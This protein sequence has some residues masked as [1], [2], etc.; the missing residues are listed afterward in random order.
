MDSRNHPC[1]TLLG[2]LLLAGCDIGPTA[3]SDTQ[4]IH[5]CTPGGIWRAPDG[6]VTIIDESLRAHVVQPGG[7]QFVGDVV[8]VSIKGAGRDC[9]LDHDK[10]ELHAV[11]PVGSTLPDGSASARGRADASW[12]KRAGNLQLDSNLV[13]ANNGTYVLSFNGAYDSLHANDSSRANVAGSY[14]PAADP[15]AEV[16]TIDAT[17]RAF[18]QNSRTGCVL[19][20][21]IDPVSSNFNVYRAS[22]TYGSCQGALAVLNGAPGRG[23]GYYDRG[24]NP[25]ELFL[26]LD[27]SA[28]TQH[29]STI[30]LLRRN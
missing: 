15:D 30:M 2:T 3:I 14:R 9:F 21:T 12:D 25:G 20:G 16:L 6:A 19:N 13:T 5:D 4:G 26:A 1:L 18:S 23:L 11:L 24:K 10:S 7:L 22:F 27:F 17:G 8:G 29:Y 28:A